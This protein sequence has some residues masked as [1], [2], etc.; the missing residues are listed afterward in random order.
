MC[1]DDV[2]IDGRLTKDNI[3]KT[4]LKTKIS[5]DYKLAHYIVGNE[6]NEET[7]L[8]W[9][10]YYNSLLDVS[11]DS[12]HTKLCKIKNCRN[13]GHYFNKNIVHS[14]ILDKINKIH[15]RKGLNTFFNESKNNYEL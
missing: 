11:N 15:L 13:I 12:Y 8:F 14:N 7:N 9:H 1:Q 10:V 3:L 5:T 6:I 4:R 2:I